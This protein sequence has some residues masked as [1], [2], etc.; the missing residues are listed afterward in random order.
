MNVNPLTQLYKDFLTILDETV[1]K[2]KTKADNFETLDIKRE[3]DRFVIASRSEDTFY[4]YYHYDKEVLAKVFNLPVEHATII[5]YNSDRTLIPENRRNEVL[6]AQRQYIIDNYV[7]RNNYY[8]ML[9]GYPDMEVPKDKFITVKD[10]Q[11]ITDTDVISEYGFCRTYMW[12]NKHNPD[13]KDYFMKTAS[14]VGYIHYHENGVEYTDSE[15]KIFCGNWNFSSSVLSTDA[16]EPYILSLADNITDEVPIHRMDLQYITI[17]N[18]TG[19]IKSLIEAYPQYEYLKYLGSNK[20]DLITARTGLNFSLLRVPTAIE[21]TAWVNF[22]NIYEQCRDYFMTCIYIPEYRDIIDYYDNFIGMCIMVMTIQQMFSRVIKNSINRDFYDKYSVK[23]L[24]ETYSVPF[25]ENMDIETQQ[26]IV[27]NLNNLIQN[28][29]TNNA[30]Y[31]ICS[32]LGFDRLKLFKYYIVRT[33]KFDRV[34]KEDESGNETYELV[35]VVKHRDDGTSPDWEAMYDVFFQKVDVADTDVYTALQDTTN[36]ATYESVVS[37]D[38]FWV[39]DDDLYKE[40]WESEYN[41]LETKYLGVTI[42]Y[43]MSQ[44]LIQNA[45]LLNMIYDNK[46]KINGILLDL[47]KISYYND[48][49]LFD[50]IVLLTALTCKQNHLKG[51]IITKPTKMLHVMGFNFKESFVAIADSIKRNP[52]IPEDI[53]DP[54][55]DIKGKLYNLILNISA[56]VALNILDKAA[57]SSLYKYMTELQELLNN[58]MSVADTK[59]AYDA[60]KSL[61]DTIFYT[62]YNQAMFKIGVRTASKRKIIPKFFIPKNTDTDEYK[63]QPYY[64]QIDG[65]SI[66]KYDLRTGECIGW[67]GTNEVFT[68]K[69]NLRSAYK[70]VDGENYPTYEAY[71]ETY[72]ISV[73]DGWDYLDKD[74]FLITEGLSEASLELLSVQNMFGDTYIDNEVPKYASTYEEYLQYQAPELYDFLQTVTD[75]TAHTYISYIA[76]KVMKFMNDTNDNIIRYTGIS[77]SMSESVENML[78]ELVRFFKSYTTDM[79][80]FDVIYTF[81]FKSESL[82]RMVDEVCRLHANIKTDD[83]YLIAYKDHV[84]YISRIRKFSNLLF[85]DGIGLLHGYLLLGSECYYDTYGNYFKRKV[86]NGVPVYN[87]Y[88]KMGN[89]INDEAHKNGYSQE[90]INAGIITGIYTKGISRDNFIDFYDLIARIHNNLYPDETITFDEVLYISSSFGVREMFKF[91]TQAAIHSELHTKDKYIAFKDEIISIISS[92]IEDATQLTDSTQH[93]NK[94]TD[95]TSILGLHDKV[96][97]SY[98]D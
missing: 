27:Q 95:R 71:K 28:K 43:K 91:I 18:S 25:N 44:L 46:D 14:D 80:S 76:N 55:K 63:N 81:D 19:H 20:I 32:I 82:T 87:Y 67:V 36:K 45:Y 53:K 86:V 39:E 26:Q 7:E 16:A 84:H 89:V 90:Y 65:D 78:I 2:Y 74:G 49:S 88:D 24:F 9:N 1:I 70:E 98:N 40:I 62:Q 3:A 12:I 41:I 52:Y 75:E 54:S 77:G 72:F 34:R 59:G 66:N 58:L 50:S 83:K 11:R 33:R 64:L 92:E 6:L 94:I 85:K 56:N 35:P 73:D 93:R 47:P 68:D 29:G 96:I 38:P 57:I 31:D 22:T 30:I 60:Y 10:I 48:V 37:A 13:E 97:I 23:Y 42:S 61:Y 8:R 51:E 15:N 17:L 69:Y 5:G 21:E 4:T 79:L